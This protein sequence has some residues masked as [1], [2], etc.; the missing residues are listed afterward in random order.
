MARKEDSA[1]RVE[2]GSDKSVRVAVITATGT[3]LAA[4][5]TAIG[6]FKSGLVTYTGPGSAPLPQD[7]S[8]DSAQNGDGGGTAAG[9][10]SL[11]GL[12]SVTGSNSI[13]SGP[14]RVNARA[15]SDTVYQYVD[16][17]TKHNAIYQLDRHYKYFDAIIG[18]SDDSRSGYT[19]FFTVTVDDREVLNQRVAVGES[20][21]IRA[22]VN[23]GYRMTISVVSDRPEGRCPGA[24]L[25]AVW[26]NPTLKPSA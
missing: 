3:V 25:V 16:C 10:V 1:S 26:A 5:I 19:V 13:N 22:D 7:N 2:R 6:S 17:E 21:Q 15:Y 20:Q 11:T 8:R 24:D 14:R 9:S 18:P 23:G 4:V 12:K